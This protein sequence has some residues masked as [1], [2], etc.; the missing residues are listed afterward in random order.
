MRLLSGYSVQELF[1]LLPTVSECS[2]K[3]LEIV[4]VFHQDVSQHQLASELVFMELR[5]QVAHVYRPQFE[6]WH[7]FPKQTL[8]IF[9]VN[10][11]GIDKLC[12]DQ[13]R[14]L[15]VEENWLVDLLSL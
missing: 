5:L 1:L 15:L 2:L 13:I 10:F 8:V 7:Q 9:L 11:L 3:A 6:V 14:K 12:R 4:L